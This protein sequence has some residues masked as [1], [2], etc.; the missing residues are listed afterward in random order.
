[1]YSD[2]GD[3]ITGKS[4][5]ER[6]LKINE[7][8]YGSSHEKVATVLMNLGTAYS[9]LGDAVTA[10]FYLERALE[11]KEKIYGPDHVELASVLQI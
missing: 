11:I 7:K 6:A 3:A 2:L 1:M 8:F 9:D 10:K 5:Q 4:Y